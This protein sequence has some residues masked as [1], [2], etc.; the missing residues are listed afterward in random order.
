MEVG[1]IIHNAGDKA[2]PENLIKTAKWAE[3]LGYHSIWLTDHVA[4]KEEVKL[5]A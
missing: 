5:A 3:A 4:L 1:V 2:S